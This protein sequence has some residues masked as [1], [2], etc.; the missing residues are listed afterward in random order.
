MK[1]LII[2]V[3]PLVFVALASAAPTTPVTFADFKGGSVVE[4]GRYATVADVSVTGNELVFNVRCQQPKD[5]LNAKATLHD[6]DVYKDDCVE[7]YIDCEGKGKDYMQYIINPLGA[8]QDLRYRARKWDSAGT[9]TADIADD[10][11]TVTLRVPLHEIAAQVEIEDGAA[12]IKINICRTVRKR[13]YH[14]SLLD[15]GVF[16]QMKQFV[17]IRLA[18]VTQEKL[19]GEF[20]AMLSSKGVATAELGKLEG[21]AF[22]KKGRELEA[23]TLKSKFKVLPEGVA[24]Y[25]ATKTNVIPNPRFE[26]VNLKEEPANWIRQGNGTVTC[27]QDGVTLKSSEHLELWQETQPVLDNTREYALRAKVRSVSG[28]NFFKVKLTGI[29]RSVKSLGMEKVVDEK[30]SPAFENNGKWTDVE[31][32]FTLPK[33]AF[34]GEAGIVVEGGELQVKEI[35]LDF[36]GREYAEIIVSQMG[37]HSKGY[38]DAIFWSRKG[39]LAPDFELVQNGKTVYK[40]RAKQFPGKPYDRETYVADFS[41]FRGEGKY[42]LKTN[43]MQSRAFKISENA[44]LDGMRFLLNGFYL[45]RQGI[46]QPGWKSKPDYMDDAIIVD[47]KARGNNKLLYTSDGQLNP[48]LILGRRDL[49]G[50]W[51]DA[52]DPSKQGSDGENIYNLARVMYWLNPI[53]RQSKAKM[54]DLAD[55]LWWGCGRWVEKCHLGDGTFVG[56]TVNETR[57]CP[58]VCRAPENCTDGIVG[59]KDDRIA[60]AERGADGKYK[61]KLGNQWLHLHTIGLTGLAM[62]KHDTA[63]TAKCTDTMDKYYRNLLNL[64]DKWELEKKKVWERYD[65]G[66]CAG[67]IAYSAIYLHQLTGKDEYKQMADKMLDRIAYATINQNYAKYDMEQSFQKTLH[68]FNVLLEYAEFYPQ[69]A[70]TQQKVKPAIKVYIDHVV[71]PGYDESELFPMFNHARLLAKYGKKGGSKGYTCLNT[72]CV[73]T[74]LRAGLILGDKDYTVLADKTAQYWLGRNPQNISEVSGLGWRN[75]ALMTGLSGCEGHVDA[76]LPGLMANGFRY[77]GF[78]PLLA[79]PAEI[80]PGGTIATSYGAEAYCVP[81]GF[82]IALLG[83]LERIYAR[84]K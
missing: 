70:L 63:I 57:H 26:Y 84:R 62:K 49:T 69:D 18:G 40:G 32:V 25:F 33:A 20:L 41:D 11:W 75:V 28:K 3:F 19:K 38:K 29:D 61:G 45:Q 13:G 53:W 56:D 21:E 37:Y 9:A 22:Y 27:G 68:Y 55:E 67:K 44:Y 7:I 17:K 64:Y 47:S 59:T 52:G 5:S 12:C 48:E 15:G 81:T 65:I 54:T 71:L 66:R 31:F 2:A 77:M 8:L 10:N 42:C 24:Y 46:A 16:S 6:R 74:L 79:K 36:L 39:G 60:F 82:E 34:R 4:G 78:M 1:K 14:E 30:T 73:T 23:Q 83:E 35:E 76:V 72:L 50:G 58:W 51:R 43:G 80:N